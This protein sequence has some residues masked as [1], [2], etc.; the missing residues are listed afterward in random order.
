[1][2]KNIYI[3]LG[4]AAGAVLR[5][6]VRNM[7]LFQPADKIPVSTLAVNITG[8]LIL[9]FFLTLAFEISNF[10]PDIRIGFSTGF[11]GAFTTFS[12]LCKETSILIFNDS[13]FWASLYI[14]LSCILGFAAAYVGYILAKKVIMKLTHH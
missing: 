13:Y 8:A 11:L 9:A 7:D 14:A 3:M 12:T 4:G 6:L 10:D 5:V 1:V 2:R